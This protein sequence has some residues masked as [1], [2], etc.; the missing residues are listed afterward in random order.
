MRQLA[1]RR[2]DA[3]MA[4]A[5]LAACLPV[6]AILLLA[7]LAAISVVDQQGPRTGRGE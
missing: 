7:G 3:G 6:L 1:A 5:E 2:R 4:T